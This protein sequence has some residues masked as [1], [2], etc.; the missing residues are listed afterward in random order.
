M[1]ARFSAFRER[2][3]EHFSSAGTMGAPQPMHDRRSSARIEAPYPAR[4]R[5]VDVTGQHFK[6]ETVLQNLSGGGLYLLMN[7]LLRE[8]TEVSLAVRL[9]IDASADSS[10]LRLAARGTVLRVEQHANGSYGVAVEFSRRRI[11]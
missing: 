7:R 3:Y 8:G 1:I 5:G 10:A 11:L 2:V 9:S 4:L 6:E